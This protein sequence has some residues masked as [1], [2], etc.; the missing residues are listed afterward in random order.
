[1][2]FSSAFAEEELEAESKNRA[3]GEVTM[4]SLFYTNEQRRLLEIV[5]QE[6]VTESQL[7]FD[8]FV[9]LVLQHSE[10]DFA[11]LPDELNKPVRTNELK[12]N[13]YIKNNSSGTGYLW[14]NNV[15]YPMNDENN[16]IKKDTALESLSFLKNDT[17]LIGKDTSSNSRFM[18]KV[19]QKIST[20][21]DLLETYPVIKVRRK[22]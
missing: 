21:G 7:D 16:F 19:G 17:G 9:P 20:N 13:A 8:E 1:M 10:E 12:F 18:V 14:I 15:A 5:R 6:I 11:D 22:N 4:P 2:F 3:S